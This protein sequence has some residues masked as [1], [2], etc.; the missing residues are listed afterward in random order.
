MKLIVFFFSLLFLFSCG[1]KKSEVINSPAEGFDAA[2][3]DPAAIELA[4][5]I[6]IAMGGRENWDKTR[7]FLEFLWTK[8]LGLGQENEQ[9]SC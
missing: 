8:E 4:D 6:M 5:S 3:S 2:N 9:G 7:L 1:G